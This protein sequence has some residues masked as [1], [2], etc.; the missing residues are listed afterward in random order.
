[1][2]GKSSVQDVSKFLDDYKLARAGML[3]QGLLS[4]VDPRLIMREI[5]EFK[6]KIANSSLLTFLRDLSEFPEI[7]ESDDPAAS[8]TT[9]LGRCRQYVEAGTRTATK[10][11][12]K[13]EP[14]DSLLQFG[15]K[16]KTK[17]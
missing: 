13:D 15:D 9:L 3:E 7:V 12:N 17:R 1:M 4:D 8:G 6:I 10:P 14:D 2:Q 11:Q 5:E 16:R